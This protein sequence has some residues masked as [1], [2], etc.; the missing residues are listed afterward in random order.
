MDAPFEKCFFDSPLSLCV[1]L[2]ISEN[3]T[4]LSSVC[5]CLYYSYRSSFSMQTRAHANLLYQIAIPIPHAMVI[6]PKANR[7]P[8]EMHSQ[9]QI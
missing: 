5:V 9:N 7:Y 4:A 8:H 1:I 6:T 3:G 2:R